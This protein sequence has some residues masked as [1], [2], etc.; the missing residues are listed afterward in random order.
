MAIFNP[1]VVPGK[2]NMPDYTKQH[3]IGDIPADKSTAIALT[4][5]GQGIEGAASLAESTAK[6]II[7]KDVRDTVDPIREDFTKQLEIAKA[8]GNN[9]VV[10][11]AVQPGSGDRTQVLSL[12]DEGAPNVPSAITQGVSK[13][14]SIQNA[15]TNGKIN[16]TYYDLNLK[17][18][19]TGLRSK[20]PGFTDYI[21]QRVAQITGVNPANEYVKNLMQDI[22]RAQTNKKTEFDKEL[23]LARS[24][25]TKG[26]P[27]ADVWMRALE[28]NGESFLP[29]FREWYAG[30]NSKWYRLQLD[31][32]QRKNMQGSVE[33]IK[34]KRTAD[35]T[36]EVGTTV[37]SN[38]NSLVTIAGVDTPQGIFDFVKKV[39]ANPEQYTDAQMKQLATQIL[40]QKNVVAS[41]LNSRANAS[42]VGTDGRTYSY[43]SDIGVAN[44]DAIIK[45]QLATYDA[46]YDALWNG[47]S[48]GAG[49][50]FF[51]ANQ[52]IARLAD[53]KDNI[54]S[55]PAGRDIATM[56]VLNESL[57]PNWG[58]IVI[59]DAL[60]ANV[61][62]K[63][64]PLFNQS[65]TEARAQPTFTSEG[66]PIT[67]KQHQDEALK[68]QQEGK[69]TEQQRGRYTNSLVNIVDDIK[70]KDAP[71]GAKI[72]ALRYFFSPEGRGILGGIKTDYT[73]PQ[74]GKFVPG[75]YSVFNRLTSQ[76]IVNEVS[77]LSKSDPSVGQMYKNYLENEAGSQLFYKE[78]QNLN[79][80]T[81]H[82]DLHF[83]YDSDNHRINLIDKEGKPAVSRPPTP[84]VYNTNAPQQDPGYIY[85]VQ[86]VVNRV[87]DGLQGLGRVEAGLGGDVNN[88]LLNF[89]QR[90]Q[91]DLGKNW[92]GLP[93]K[94]VDAIAASR[95]PARRIEDTFNDAKGNK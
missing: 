75:K 64:R 24:A 5:I 47:G 7:N 83:A 81:G 22:N 61:D 91:V 11:N 84:G 73:D 6:D 33:D 63:I 82:D 10:P 41:Q 48:G 76:D 78:L 79:R 42:S 4:T 92:E 54:L 80:Y 38:L 20:Y 52:A 3:A 51:H 74:T 2:D 88:Y 28:Q 35:F 94:L 26:L 86:Q 55:G 50:A 85:R 36:N 15:Y 13:V 58:S 34:N 8:A 77:R 70:N 89:M 45:S 40:A 68:L 56:N 37:Q 90:S 62:Q 49:L 66:K 18:A 21:D 25:M 16:D 67:F 31:D 23:D 9:S 87:N 44:K 53:R 30:E 72:N 71:D 43:T 14:E 65:M 59:N 69:I 57:G 95:S 27:N 60:R 12:Q 29:K 32:A 1:Q 46:I 93:Q 39:A 19:V 17:N